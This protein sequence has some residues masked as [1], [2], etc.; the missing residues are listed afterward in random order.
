MNHPF[1]KYLLLWGLLL[2]AATVAA[3]VR[4]TVQGGAVPTATARNIEKQASALL[5]ELNVSYADHSQP[6][7]TAAGVSESAQR[8][9]ANLWRYAPFHCLSEEIVRSPLLTS[10]GYQVRD[11]AIEFVHADG[12]SEFQEGILNFDREGNLQSMR[13]TLP[14]H[15]VSQLLHS[16]DSLR[17]RARLE[18]IL[19]YLERYRTAYNE[20][21]ILFLNQVYSDDALIIIGQVIETVTDKMRFRDC[22]YVTRT[23]QEYIRRLSEVFRQNK[24]IQVDFDHVRVLIHPAQADYYGVLLHQSYSTDTDRDEGYLF[25]F[26]DFRD[27]A[28]PMIHVRRWE[29]GETFRVPDGSFDDALDNFM[30]DIR[31]H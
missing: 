26:W 7:L 31:F 27:T 28:R 15:M 8:Q 17:D 24:R 1:R 20:K 21:D 12:T 10:S 5:T 16:G 25:L 11:I 14:R 23:K 2:V 22:V 13:L 4:V 3:H 19:D 30:S 9:V 6:R 18:L 29:P